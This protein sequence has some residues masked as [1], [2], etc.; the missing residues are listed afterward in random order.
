MLWNIL[1]FWNSTLNYFLIQDVIHLGHFHI[2]EKYICIV[3]LQI[4]WILHIFPHLLSTK[5][6]LL[7]Y[8]ARVCGFVCLFISACFVCGFVYVYFCQLFLHIL[9]H[10]VI[11][12]K[13]HYVLLMNWPSHHYKKS[14]F[15]SGNSPSLK[16]CLAGI[17]MAIEVSLYLRFR[18]CVVF[19]FTALDIFVASTYTACRKHVVMLFCIVS[20]LSYSFCLLVSVFSV[21]TWNVIVNITV[22]T[23]VTFCTLTLSWIPHPHSQLPRF[24]FS[25]FL[26]DH[27]NFI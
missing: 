22:F 6:R 10:L 8:T 18:Y 25:H 3:I 19:Q 21:F 1:T 27:L 16:D 23:F 9:W 15:L 4:S 12:Y 2:D 7:K 11:Q 13:K 20:N 24:L 26:S 17:C 14:S 5:G